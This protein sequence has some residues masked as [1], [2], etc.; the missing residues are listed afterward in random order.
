[1]PVF[2]ENTVNDCKQIGK[3]LCT[4]ENIYNKLFCFVC[5][6]LNHKISYI[7]IHVKLYAFINFS[8]C[9]SKNVSILTNEVKSISNEL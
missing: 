2:G 7:Y 3:Y 9:V 1:M 4:T 8:T 5:L 6:H